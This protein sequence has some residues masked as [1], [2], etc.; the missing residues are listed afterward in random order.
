[1]K[2]PLRQNAA[3]SGDGTDET[4]IGTA[5]ADMIDGAGGNDTL[6]GLAGDD[7]L[8]GGTGDD[9]MF[10]GADNDTYYVDSA[11]D[12]V[13]EA[14]G[15]GTDRIATAVSYVLAAGSAIERLDA[16][17]YTATTA[18]NLTGNELANILIGNAGANILDG[19]GG[20]DIMTGGA[21]DDVYHV[22]HAGDLVKEEAGGG[23]DRVATMVSYALTAAV[24]IETL[25]TSSE[26]STTAINLTGNDLAQVLIGNA[27]ANE[28]NGGAGND[29][30]VGL[31]GNDTLIG[32]RGLDAMYGGTG[33]DVYFID[34]NDTMFENA[35]EGNDRA[36][37]DG[38]GRLTAG[39]EIER[40][41]AATP[42]S[43]VSTTLRGNEF[44]NTIVGSDGRN[45]MSG[46]G[47]HDT[48]YGGGGDDTLTG[49]SSAGTMYG[50][51]GN[52]TFWV[53]DPADAV[54]ENVGEGA[55]RIAASTSYALPAGSEVEILEALHTWGNAAFN[56]TGNALAQTL[57]GNTGANVLDGKGGNDVL[58]G[59]S[60]ADT[61]AFTTGLGAGNVDTIQG[62]LSGT[63]KI[64][65][66]DAV[67]TAVVPGTLA[68]GAFLTG[69]AAQDGDDR[70]IYDSATGALYYDSDGTGASAQMQ[71]ATLDA[72]TPLT[73]SDFLLI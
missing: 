7:I 24:Q 30:L 42:S 40:L 47:G 13:D 60:G 52:D 1:M 2:R 48:M 44:N 9:I 54:I 67:F 53:Y 58:N 15:E 8:V 69:T 61:Y 71:F 17:H 66:D 73:G 18:I 39:Q 21:G 68:A 28:L 41:E 19:R 3:I 63:D 31:G 23:V 6:S 37:A 20:A 62:F 46:G 22:D 34:V 57:I 10:G 16:L 55:D 35:G 26:S 45:S 12:L 59:H 50:G 14:T 33:D 38:S 4:L 43:T 51:L 36:L 25:E 27:G 32:G 5:D 56:F 49:S 70:I 11:G 29:R 64:A 72:G 65:L